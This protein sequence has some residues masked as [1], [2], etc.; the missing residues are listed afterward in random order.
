TSAGAGPTETGRRRGWLTDGVIGLRRLGPTDVDFFHELQNQPD[1]MATN[2]PPGPADRA[3]IVTRCDRA[4]ARWLAGE[5]A[6]L[7]L[8]DVAS[9]RPAGAVALYYEQPALRE[10]MVAYSLLPAWRGRGYPTRAVR[11]LAGWAFREAGIARLFG[12]T[13]PTNVASQRVLEKAGFRREGVLRGQLPGRAGTRA[14][15]VV[16]GLLPTD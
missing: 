11:L 5:Q 4:A 6:D 8:V 1:V 13:L 9:G 12:G 7:V 10:A 2:V 3:K 15:D 16:F 14:D